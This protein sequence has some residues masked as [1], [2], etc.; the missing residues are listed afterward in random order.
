[1]CL[2]IDE[3]ANGCR[4]TDPTRKITVT[5]THVIFVDDT[6]LM[7]KFQD[8]EATPSEITDIVQTDVNIWN[9]GINTTGGKLEGSKSKYYILQWKFTSSGEPYLNEDTENGNRVTLEG[10]EEPTILQRI[11]HNREPK[12]FKSLGTY[13]PGSLDNHYEYKIAQ[14]KVKKYV[15][16]LN[17]CPLRKNEAWISY[18]QY[19]LPS[20]T[21]GFVAVSFSIE[22][23]E[24]LHRQLYPKL[25]QKLGYKAHTPRP[26]VYAPKES[27]GVG[28]IDFSALI[29]VRKVQLIMRHLRA[30]TSIGRLF[31]VVLHWAQLQ[32]G[33]STSILSDCK[34]LIWKVTGWS[35]CDKDCGK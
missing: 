19:F 6:Y 24:T 3:K 8:P 4:I 12:Q 25:L 1:M 5:W 32:A 11:N 22:Q 29:T 30:N 31:T 2:A 10:S 28:L 18:K 33:T 7:H 26:I 9:K 16:F 13:I 21:Y 15:K 23:C 35:N 17:S 14:L 27:G 20:I 34:P